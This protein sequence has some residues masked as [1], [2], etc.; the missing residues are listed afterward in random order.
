M[1]IKNAPEGT[2]LLGALFTLLL[3]FI[4]YHLP[5]M[6]FN[7]VVSHNKKYRGAHPWLPIFARYTT[8]SIHLKVSL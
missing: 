7:G 2:S 5:M 8:L 3:Y 6:A 4:F 1:D